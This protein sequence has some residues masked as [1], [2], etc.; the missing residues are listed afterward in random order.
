MVG[1]QN[2]HCQ[3]IALGFSDFFL[4]KIMRK[5]KSSMPNK[6]SPK[7]GGTTANFQNP[8]FALFFSFRYWELRNVLF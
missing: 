2:L 4:G 6:Y 3:H 8:I 7:E 1:T 5:A